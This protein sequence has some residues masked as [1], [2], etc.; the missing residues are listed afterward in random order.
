MEHQKL[1]DDLEAVNG[2]PAKN[3]TPIGTLGI[4]ELWFR[5]PVYSFPAYDPVF[6]EN[7]P[8]QF[9]SNHHPMIQE[10]REKFENS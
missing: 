8:E 3:E 7:E 9:L 10:C 5:K 4:D 6:S 1:F 2:S